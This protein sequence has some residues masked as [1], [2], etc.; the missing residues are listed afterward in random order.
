MKKQTPPFRQDDTRRAIVLSS[1]KLFSE[2]GIEGVSLTQVRKEANQH[3]RSVIYYYFSSKEG[4]LEAVTEYVWNNISPEFEKSSQ[5][6][7]ALKFT[8]AN[9]HESTEAIINSIIDPFLNIYFKHAEGEQ[10]VRYLLFLM[11]SNSLVYQKIAK[12]FISN[13]TEVFLPLLKK[14]CNK[15]NNQDVS[16]LVYFL[17]SN[18]LNMLASISKLFKMGKT[19]GAKSDPNSAL[20]QEVKKFIVDY[21]TGAVARILT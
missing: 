21:Q 3:N 15:K 7:K 11:Q 17:I 5:M 2:N 8:S 14:A 10:S 18:T 12:E 20:A 19:R 9:L 13:L 1:L 4:L 16:T 6:A